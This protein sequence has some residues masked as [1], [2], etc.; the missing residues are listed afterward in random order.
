MTNT[1][2]IDN[3]QINKS[4]QAG[5][6]TARMQWGVFGS[7]G[8]FLTLFEVIDVVPVQ[9]LNMTTVSGGQTIDFTDQLS[10]RWVNPDGGFVVM[11]VFTAGG[12]QLPGVAAQKTDNGIPNGLWSNNGVPTFCSVTP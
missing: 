2:N 10:I 9:K 5:D 4:G 7:D 12:V 3:L 6:G 1:T 11:A 8:A